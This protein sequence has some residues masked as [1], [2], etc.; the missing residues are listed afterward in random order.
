MDFRR[1]K[2]YHDILSEQREQ[3]DEHLIPATPVR[4]LVAGAALALYIAAMM[5]LYW[6]SD[7]TISEGA[8]PG[9]VPVWKHLLGLALNTAALGFSAIFAVSLVLWTLKQASPKFALVFGVLGFGAGLLVAV[10]L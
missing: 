7:V 1:D 6:S 4:W 9:M 8:D 10:V 3:R 5:G 2:T